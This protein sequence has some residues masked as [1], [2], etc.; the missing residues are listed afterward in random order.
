[1]RSRPVASLKA[2]AVREER[3]TSVMQR[4]P[5]AA[6]ASEECRSVTYRGKG[7]MNDDVYN[8]VF[9]SGGVLMSAVLDAEGRMAGGIIAPPGTAVP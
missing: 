8:L 1:M 9:A 7:G 6:V 4:V 2:Y 5:Y 3:P